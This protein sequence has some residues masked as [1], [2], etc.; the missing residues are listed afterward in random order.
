M[1]GTRSKAAGRETLAKATMV[2][3]I[4]S[5]R[6]MISINAAPGERS[7]KKISDQSVFK[8]SCP[9]NIPRAIFTSFLLIP[10]R[11]TRKAAIPISAKSTDH[12]GANTD[13]RGD[14]SGLVRVTYQLVTDDIVNIDPMMPASPDT[15][16]AT[17]NLIKLVRFIAI[18]YTAREQKTSAFTDV[19][20][21]DLSYA[22]IYRIWLP[23]L[24]AFRTPIWRKVIED[25]ALFGKVFES[26]TY[27][28]FRTVS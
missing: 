16:I 18:S 3:R 26:H 14:S 5:Q 10:F 27:G 9:R 28:V 2:A 24:D 21:S 23:G 1:Y 20:L 12:M 7:L 6:N 4:A 15:A 17:S 13:S 11:H 19:V 25:L 22:S 8:T